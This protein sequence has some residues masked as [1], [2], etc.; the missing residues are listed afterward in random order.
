MFE[1]K[2][3]RLALRDLLKEDQQAIHRLR[4]DPDVIRYMEYIRSD[5]AA[6]T[7][8]R[9]Q[10]TIEH[11]SLKPSQS[12]NLVIKRRSDNQI[13][14]KILLYGNFNLKF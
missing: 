1:I 13:S 7:W 12:Y 11:N 5:T 3:H 10:E 14:G 6:E 9:I 8:A 2:T 4:S